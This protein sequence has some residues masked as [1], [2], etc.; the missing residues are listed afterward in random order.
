MLNDFHH[1]QEALEKRKENGTLRILRP[2]EQG[3][4]FYSN[5]YLGLA[6]NKVFGFSNHCTVPANQPGTGTSG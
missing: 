4:D 6:G 5:D 3:I 1:F 2:K